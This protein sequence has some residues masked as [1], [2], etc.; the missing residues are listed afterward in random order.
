VSLPGRYLRLL[1]SNARQK[2]VVFPY[3]S[4]TYLILSYARGGGKKEK[5]IVANNL[6]WTCTLG[7]VVLDFFVLSL[8]QQSISSPKLP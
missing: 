2:K 6:I 7:F 4:L 3:L 8:S 5:K 1:P